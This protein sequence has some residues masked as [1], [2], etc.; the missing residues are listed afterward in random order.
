MGV[1]CLAIKNYEQSGIMD[2]CLFKSINLDFSKLTPLI[3]PSNHKSS[4]FFFTLIAFFK[5]PAAASET[6]Q[7]QRLRDEELC[8]L[9]I[10]CF[11][12]IYSFYYLNQ[13]NFPIWFTVSIIPTKWISIS[14][15][16]FL[17]FQPNDFP[18][19]IYYF[20]HFSLMNFPIYL[21]YSSSFQSN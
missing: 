15:L 1:K 11:E 17:L 18:H 7:T 14:D 19:L 6:K 16:L 8:S 12:A 20:Y 21:I 13:M 4:G 5:S 9:R 2:I 10:S 3:S